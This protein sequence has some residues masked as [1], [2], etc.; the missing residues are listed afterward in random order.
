MLSTQAQTFRQSLSTPKYAFTGL[1]VLLIAFI[2]GSLS[3]RKEHD[4]RSAYLQSPQAGDVYVLYKVDGD[5]AFPY[6][7][8]RVIEA[9]ATSV[10]LEPGRRRS[11]LESGVK[12]EMVEDDDAYLEGDEITLE[13]TRLTEGLVT[14]VYRLGAPAKSADREI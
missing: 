13:R 7:Y 6:S 5:A 4:D 11:N 3:I 10:R 8:A 14:K 2:A 12:R 9:D 1:V